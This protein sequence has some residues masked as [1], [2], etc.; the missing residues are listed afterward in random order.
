MTTPRELVFVYDADSNAW[1]KLFDA[2]HKI[3]SPATYS[4]SLCT[5]TYGAFSMHRTWASFVGS[6]P[7]PVRFAYRD[8]LRREH[9]ALPALPA[10]LERRGGAWTTLLAREQIAACANLEELI[11][12]VREVVA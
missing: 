10:L 2:A 5:L 1:S 3:V 6:L 9:V 7:H 8:Q 11:E 12:R 4:C